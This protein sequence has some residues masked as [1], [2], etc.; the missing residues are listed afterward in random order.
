[1]VGTRAAKKVETMVLLL[2]GLKVV[3]MV[4]MMADNS[5][6]RMAVKKVY[7]MVAL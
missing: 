1:L 6:E 2:V 3:T 5:A 4:L 7:R